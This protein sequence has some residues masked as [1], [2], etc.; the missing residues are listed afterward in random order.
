MFRAEATIEDVVYGGRGLARLNGYVVFVPRVLAGERVRLEITRPHKTYA[1][2]R[3]LE[4]LAPSPHR[5]LAACPLAE[6]C[7]GCAYQH[8]DYAEEL[9]VKHRQLVQFFR[10][11]AVAQGPDIFPPP[12]PSLPCLGYR[13]R[14]TL[15]A[16]I[17]ADHPPRLGYKASNNRTVVDVPVCPLARISINERLAALRADPHFFRSLRDGEHLT[18]RATA[19]DGVLMWRNDTSP[20]KERLTETTAL[21]AIRVP[22]RSFFQVNGAVADCL[23]GWLMEFVRIRQPEIMLDLCC[24]VGMFSLAAARAGTPYTWGMDVDASAILAA[25]SNA[26]RLDCR[27]CAF[28]TGSIERRL[29]G[30]LSRLPL[31]QTLILANPPRS[32]LS[33]AVIRHLIESEA[34]LL[35]YISCAPD[36]LARDVARLSAG[37]WRVTRAQV[38]D[39]FP[40]TACFECVAVLERPGGHASFSADTARPSGAGTSAVS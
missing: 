19:T 9:R 25:R 15:H 11:T 1:E 36:R 27:G 40:R 4:V 5:R 3:L 38:F 34:A 31:R 12:A 8:M 7:G 26:R 37:G 29:A 22:R 28:E 35:V 16:A 14:I 39:M 13:N 6:T 30:V 21:G 18:L 24:G 33:P 2:S 20:G 23:L 10:P 17:Q 32:G